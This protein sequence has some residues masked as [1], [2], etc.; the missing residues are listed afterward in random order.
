MLRLFSGDPA[1]SFTPSL[2]RRTLAV[3]VCALSLGLSAQ[4]LAQADD[5]VAAARTAG[6]VGEQ[7]SG[8]EVGTLG[9]RDEA[10]ANDD[11]RRRVAQINGERRQVYFDRA[12]SRSQELGMTVAPAEMAAATACQLLANRVGVGEWY[13]DEAGA[14][15]QRTASAPVAR[16][17]FC[18]AS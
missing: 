16:P 13:R 12:A 7:A 15:R 9:I 3:A 5:V 10:R 14:W 4:A 11:L 6:I 1:M 18:P 17:S 2:L 8:T